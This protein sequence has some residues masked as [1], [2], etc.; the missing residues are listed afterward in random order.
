M[1]CGLE[2]Y[3]N[4]AYL[5]PTPLHSTVQRCDG[6]GST[7]LRSKPTTSRDGAVWVTPAVII[8]NGGQVRL[9]DCNVPGEGGFFCLVESGPSVQGYINRSYLQ[10]NH[11]LSTVQRQDAVTSTLL[12]SKPTT[13][14]DGSAFTV[15]TVQINNGD[16]VYVIQDNVQGEGSTFCLV[17]T[18]TGAQGYLNRS[19]MHRFHLRSTVQRKDGVASTLLRN[20]PTTARVASA[21]VTPMVHAH[22]GDTVSVIDDNVQGEGGIF[23][24]V[25]IGQGATQKVP[26]PP[27]P[28]PPL[29]PPLPAALPS[30]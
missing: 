27:L 5:Q 3:L 13:S 8:M 2:G 23:C 9:I 28:S 11:L 20:S 6:I 19:Y 22:N 21:W 15:P 17:Q 26:L 7:Q 18:K 30:S 4:R 24:L 16:R 10:L 12:R 29:L 1:N 25:S 14:R